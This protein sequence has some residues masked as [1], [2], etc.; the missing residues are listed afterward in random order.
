MKKGTGVLKKNIIFDKQD[1][2]IVK[3][4]AILLM[5]YYHTVAE[6]HLSCISMLNSFIGV[7]GNVCVTMFAFIS[8]YGIAKKC[9][10]I[11]RKS[12]PKVIIKRL[13]SLYGSYLPI[14]FFTLIITFIMDWINKTTIVYSA[15]ASNAGLLKS[16]AKALLDMLGLS[17]GVFCYKF[18]TINPTWWYMTVAILLIIVTPFVYIL[19]TKIQMVLTILWIPFVIITYPFLQPQFSVLIQMV[20]LVFIGIF[21]S[22]KKIFWKNR[23]WTLLI[24]L[25]IGIVGLVCIFKFEVLRH[26]T[27]FVYSL[28]TY[29]IIVVV[30]YLFRIIKPVSRFMKYMGSKSANIFYMHTFVYFIWAVT[31]NFILKLKFGVLIW[32]TTLAITLVLSYCID[33]IKEKT[34]WNKLINYLLRRI[35]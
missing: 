2:M 22:K 32:I 35:G 8:V 6:R 12:T 19:S 21:I 10:T 14:Y 30:V 17:F 29:S 27:M 31:T 16:I 33:F 9:S 11:N 15:Y 25:F 20:F 18:G 4:V 26:Y 28:I 1:S 3:G 23:I 5:V 34:R 24:H 7:T 13:I